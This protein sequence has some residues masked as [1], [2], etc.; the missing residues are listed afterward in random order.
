[1]A[2]ENFKKHLLSALFYLYFLANIENQ[3]KESCQ[4][5][6]EEPRLSKGIPAS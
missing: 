5:T 6:C 1:M 3:R 2:I 4:M